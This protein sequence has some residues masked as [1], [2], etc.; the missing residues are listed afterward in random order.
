M[1]VVLKNGVQK[2]KRDQLIEWLRAQGVTIHISEGEF[3][4]VLGAVFGNIHIP[5]G[6]P[7]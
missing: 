4:T 6:T 3:Q 7:G 1:I 2:E 5:D